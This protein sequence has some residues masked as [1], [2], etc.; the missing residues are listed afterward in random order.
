MRLLNYFREQKEKQTT[1]ERRE[2]DIYMLQAAYEETKYELM[3][4]HHRRIRLND[5]ILGAAFTVIIIVYVII[6]I[7]KIKQLRYA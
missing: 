2:A 7:Q 4:E 6:I 5:Y 1:R 3:I